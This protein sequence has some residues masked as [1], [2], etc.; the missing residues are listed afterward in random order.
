MTNSIATNS[1]SNQVPAEQPNPPVGNAETNAETPAVQDSGSCCGRI[2]NWLVN[3]IFDP[4]YRLFAAILCCKPFRTPPPITQQTNAEGN[5]AT[6]PNRT[7][8]PRP[9]PKVTQPIVFLSPPATI[10]DPLTSREAIVWP[11][12]TQLSIG[13][14]KLVEYLTC[15]DEGRE[16]LVHQEPAQAE[17]PP[18]QTLTPA[19]QAARAAERRR[20]PAIP[21]AVKMRYHLSAV[22][23]KLRNPSAV[24][25]LTL[26]NIQD[27]QRIFTANQ[28]NPAGL[29]AYQLLFKC[30]EKYNLTGFLDSFEPSTSHFHEIV[31]E[32]DVPAQE[33]LLEARP[34][35][36]NQIPSITSP[37]QSQKGLNAILQLFASSEVANLW[38]VKEPVAA[39]PVYKANETPLQTRKNHLL[40]QLEQMRINNLKNQ[41]IEIVN[42]LRSEPEAPLTKEQIQRLANLIKASGTNPFETDSTLLKFFCHFFGGTIAEFSDM[43]S[44]LFT[45]VN[46]LEKPAQI[47]QA[48]PIDAAALPADL[49]ANQK[50]I[51]K[52]VSLIAQSSIW[53]QD[54]MKELEAPNA[55]QREG[56]SNS[57]FLS[58]SLDVTIRLIA[59]QKTQAHLSGLIHLLR[60]SSQLNSPPITE[61]LTRLQQLLSI[62]QGASAHSVLAACCK[63]LQGKGNNVWKTILPET[64]R[65]VKDIYLTVEDLPEILDEVVTKPLPNIGNT[66]YMNSTLQMIARLDF[67]N[68]MLN[69]P[70]ERLDEDAEV[71]EKRIAL[72]SHLR[73]LI[74]QMR[75]PDG[76]AIKETDLKT[77]V[78]LLQVNGWHKPLGTQEDPQELV[79]FIRNA[80]NANTSIIHAF[81]KQTYLKEDDV[82]TFT[83]P[84][85][86]F[87]ELSMSL[88]IDQNRRLLPEFNTIEKLIEN[89]GKS[90]IDDYYIEKE[91]AK[92]PV[93]GET[94]LLDPPPDTLFIHQCRLAYDTQGN[95]FRIA[96]AAPFSPTIRLPFYQSEDLSE[97]PIYHNYELKVVIGHH[98]GTSTESGHYTTWVLQ[99]YPEPGSGELKNRWI[100]YDDNRVRPYSARDRDLVHT[101][102]LKTDVRNKGY[103]LAYV[104]TS[105]PSADNIVNASTN[106]PQTPLEDINPPA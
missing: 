7:A 43:Y 21:A 41:L 31:D 70:L 82:C 20:T 98:G 2:W 65:E 66:C 22:V 26:A 9:T 10:S 35:N 29:S 34:I 75:T 37:N 30:C 105:E 24:H 45:N 101:N 92:Y 78:S 55:P 61:Y 53:D 13:L 14:R 18:S 28:M 62:H 58:R 12:G 94:C 74:S 59:S 16:L 52:A 51:F 76:V 47:A 67:F 56:E 5:P 87:C 81:K 60:T 1:Q 106:P 88:P 40:A 80:L 72:Q 44:L 100:C 23:E 96:G 84:I 97:E 36:Q 8:P 27:L 3:Y 42:H 33:V 4:I 50:Q 19:A 86:P 77:L 73:A 91:D 83:K 64:W 54:L 63:K 71:F 39:E 32:M 6:T 25:P 11:Q 103:Y 85:D 46:M 49:P 57:E 15:S 93:E 17:T 89:S 102:L 79:G 38:L 68:E 104:K 69:T 95:S 90:S 99:K 48:T